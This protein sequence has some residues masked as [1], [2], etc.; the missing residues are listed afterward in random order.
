MPFARRENCWLLAMQARWW[1]CLP[2]KLTTLA[3][4]IESDICGLMESLNELLYLRELA[5]SRLE[6]P[7]LPEIPEGNLQGF[8]DFLKRF[9]ESCIKAKLTATK[10]HAG[11][12]IYQVEKSGD[13]N[14]HVVYQYCDQIYSALV[15]ETSNVVF[16]KLDKPE[17][18]SSLDHKER[19]K[20]FGDKVETAFPSAI[21]EII[22]AC[23]CFALEQWTACVF[24][25]MRVLEAPLTALAKKV[26][27]PYDT[28][29]WHNIIEGIEKAV[30]AIDQSYGIDWKDAQKFFGEAARHLMF[31]KN[32]WRNHV[33]HVR[34]VY[35]EGKA[36]SILQ[37]TRELTAHLSQQLSETP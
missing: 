34:D 33:M 1:K 27:V 10:D 36:H 20:M 8:V 23:N 24:H 30:R 6:Q 26:S 32:G 31:L 9:R 5:R 16:M 4:M 21:P 25:C 35:D 11:W 37:H 17:Y 22:G 2:P 18:Y 13:P 12:A 14:S 15:I 28:K 3:D 7:M 29:E 19:K